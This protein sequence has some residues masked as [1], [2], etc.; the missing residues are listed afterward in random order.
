MKKAIEFTVMMCTLAAIVSTFFLYRSHITIPNMTASVI[1]SRPT[2]KHPLTKTPLSETQ[3]SKDAIVS[4]TENTDQITPD[5]NKINEQSSSTE[6]VVER[7]PLEA[8]DI[9]NLKNDIYS[10]MNLSRSQNHLPPLKILTTLESYATKRSDDMI[11]RNYFSHITPDGCD[12]QCR[13]TD[14]GIVTSLWGENLAE[15]KSYVLETTKE[16]A[17]TFMTKWLKSQRHRENILSSE[18]THFGIGISTN[19]DRLIVTV[20][21]AKL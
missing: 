9:S 18:Y 12:L 4:E 5:T 19:E 20:I 11:A 2:A 8:T 15:S 7:V 3:S 13:L 21:F 1:E 17:D 10:R 14:S 16:T 6:I